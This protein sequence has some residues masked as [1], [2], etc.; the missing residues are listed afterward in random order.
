MSIQSELHITDLSGPMNR[1]FLNIN[2]YGQ[3]CNPRNSTQLFFLLY[4]TLF[5][6]YVPSLSSSLPL[7]FL[8]L[9]VLFLCLLA[10]NLS[11]LLVLCHN[12]SRRG[13]PLSG[14][15]NRVCRHLIGFLAAG[16]CPVAKSLPT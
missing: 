8:R 6:L 4:S 12:S 3:K 1:G 16:G 15:T 13:P 9:Y 14:C 2:N 11:A 5:S 7:L 10:L